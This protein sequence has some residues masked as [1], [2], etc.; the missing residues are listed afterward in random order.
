MDNTEKQGK[1]SP[2]I[3]TLDLEDHYM[4]QLEQHLEAKLGA[5]ST[6][7]PKF[8]GY[9]IPP[10]GQIQLV[11]K[12]ANNTAVKLFLVPYDLTDMPAGS[13]TFIR[14][15]SYDVGG[16]GDKQTLRYAVHLQFCAPPA[17]ERE[18]GRK[19]MASRRG[20]PQHSI[21]ASPRRAPSHSQSPTK[22]SQSSKVPSRNRSDAMTASHIYLHKNIRLVFTSRALD[23]SE[24]LKVVLEDPTGV[25]TQASSSPLPSGNLKEEGLDEVPASPA[26]GR[27]SAYTGPGEEWESLKRRKHVLDKA[28][29]A[30]QEP[31]HPVRRSN[32]PSDPNAALWNGA[33]PFPGSTGSRHGMPLL[34]TPPMGAFSTS[35]SSRRM[36]IGRSPAT[37]LSS[38]MGETSVVEADKS[39]VERADHDTPQLTAA[40]NLPEPLVFQRSVVPATVPLPAL[41]ESGLS[42]SRPSSRAELRKAPALTS[43]TLVSVESD[44]MERRTSQSPER[45]GFGPVPAS[46]CLR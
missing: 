22:V 33:S 37:S 41:I 28:C 26:A 39:D 17:K 13:K 19:K 25:Q 43:T 4:Q 30:P 31:H 16:S 44:S 12:N 14:Q 11:V 10:K 29:E 23:L 45:R 36:H 1:G 20:G 27:Y 34:N 35:G 2:Y 42:I 18:R 5:D 3:G 32:I 15:K 40:A 46:G 6:A 9:R 21:S 38:F 7:V 24:K 8:P